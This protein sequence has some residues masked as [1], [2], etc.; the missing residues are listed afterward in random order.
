VIFGPRRDKVMRGCRKVHNEERHNLYFS[1][2]V[3]VKEGDI[4]WACS[5][6]ESYKE[7]IQTWS[8]NVKGR[9]CLDDLGAER[10][11]LILKV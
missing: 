10:R 4:D 6:H 7:C 5:M 8:E 11:I 9:D 1:Q 3:I 2:Y